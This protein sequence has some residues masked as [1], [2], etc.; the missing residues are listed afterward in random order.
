ML[1]QS[2]AL[3]AK[4]VVG[5]WAMPELLRLP[6]LAGAAAEVSSAS[7]ALCAASSLAPPARSADTQS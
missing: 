3:G 6:V 2:K 1:A 7:L 5:G 4:L